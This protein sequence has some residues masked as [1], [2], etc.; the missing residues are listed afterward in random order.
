MNAFQV[1]WSK[2]L[3]SGRHIS[4]LTSK[5]SAQNNKIIFPD[6]AILLALGSIFAWKKHSGKVI[7]YTDDVFAEVLERIELL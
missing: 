5:F 4:A 1:L 3:I 7:L 6:Y 2:P